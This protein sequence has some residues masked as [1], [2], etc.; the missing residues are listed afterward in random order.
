[1]KRGNIMLRFLMLLVI[2][3]F[4]VW[5]FQY[6][7][8]PKRKLLTAHEKKQTFF[9]DDSDNV[10]RNLLLTYKGVLFEGEKYLGNTEDRFT[11]TKISIW[12]RQPNRLKGLTRDDF[13][14]ITE[15]IQASYPDAEIEWGTPVREFL[16]HE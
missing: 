10:R 14:E 8:N 16:Q 11:V 1:M 15:I 2:I 7:F 13:F 5:W 9:L 3:A 4:I 6:I 12:P